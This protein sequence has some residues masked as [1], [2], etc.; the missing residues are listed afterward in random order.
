M[1]IDVSFSIIQFVIG[2]L[3][4]SLALI[5]NGGH[6]LTDALSLLISFIAAKVSMRKASDKKTYG[7]GRATIIAA[8]INSVL[9]ILFAVF[10]FTEAYERIINPVQVDGFPIVATA[11]FGIFVSGGV[12]ALLRRHSSDLNV[13]SVSLHMSYDAVAYIGTLLAGLI[14][15]LTGQAIFDPLI[16]IMIGIF[17][18]VGAW[19][20]LQESFQILLEGTPKWVS[21]EAVR[22]AI[23]RH[24]AVLEVHDLHVWAISS[25]YAALSCHAIIGA[26]SMTECSKIIADIKRM[27]KKDFN[28]EHATIEAEIK[29]SHAGRGHR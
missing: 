21:I 9:L 11:V 1:F 15:L 19:G 8:L 12:A 7:Y 6:G 2:L 26:D 3:S 24:G 22:D 18:V 28:I 23:G 17:M 20:V 16:S 14:I 13:R 27:L 10:I 25:Q 29:N 5:S 4:G